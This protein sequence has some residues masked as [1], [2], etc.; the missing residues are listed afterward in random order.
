VRRRSSTAIGCEVFDGDGS[1]TEAG[2]FVMEL[3]E[4]FAVR[5]VCADPWQANLLLEA[6]EARGIVAS[7]FPQLVGPMS[8]SNWRSI[9]PA[10]SSAIG[11]E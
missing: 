4:T 8:L 7:A 6:L 1:A 2:K 9:E 10:T 3:V 11:T 5:E